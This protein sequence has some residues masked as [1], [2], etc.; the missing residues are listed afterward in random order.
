MTPIRVN[1][2]HFL[3]ASAAAG[4]ALTNP[5]TGTEGRAVR[6]GLIGL[7]N[8]GTNLLRTILE[9]PGA[10]IIAL[11]DPDPRA[12]RRATGICQKAGRA[13]PAVFEDAASLT[14]REDVEAILAAVPCDL[15]ATAAREAIAGGKHLY[16]EKPLAPTLAE[17]DSIR[18]AA[19]QRPDLN[20]H[21]GFQRRSNPRVREAIE[22][23]QSGELGE[24]VGCRGHWISSH[25]P[26]AGH[27]GWLACRARS[28]DWMV[29]QAVHLWDLLHWTLGSPPV[30]ATGHGQRA[31]R[32]DRDVTD[33]YHV[34]L[35]WDQP[36]ISVAFTQSWIDAP[37]GEAGVSLKVVGARGSVELHS[38]VVAFRDGR[39]R[40]VIQPGMVAD[41]RLALAGFL[42]AVRSPEPP[43]PP[44]RLAEAREAT[45]IGL[46]VREAV[47]AGLRRAVFMGEIPLGETDQ[48][49]P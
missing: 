9:L 31:E 47:D 21:V 42:A 18:S 19:A 24:I 34:V 38:G 14:S 33:W 36:S 44:V 45:R 2:R 48:S 22:L 23:I 43:P 1:R 5:V 15:H 27:D 8:R 10:E 29:E 17:C 3:G 35:G 12:T 49:L 39:P 16:L 7:G 20:V 37:D 40:R 25:G 11:A 26:V 13:I 30:V 46:L 28:G 32:P 6:I 41:T 4:L